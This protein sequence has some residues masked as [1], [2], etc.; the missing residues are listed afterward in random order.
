MVNCEHNH[1]SKRPNSPNEA[2]PVKR[3]RLRPGFRLARSAP[4]ASQSTSS[5][6]GSLFI[7]VNQPDER[8]GI[9]QAQNRILPSVPATSIAATPDLSSPLQ[10][11]TL[12]SNVPPPSESNTDPEDQPVPQGEEQTVKPKRKR[13]T[14]NAVCYSL[15]FCTQSSLNLC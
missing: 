13:N 11:S 9:L 5:S 6:I 15:N 10:P 7:T 14:K 2:P 1:M 3:T 4:V 8:R 12:E